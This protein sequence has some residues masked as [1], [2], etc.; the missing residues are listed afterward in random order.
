MQ[1]DILKV[2]TRGKNGW[3]ANGV[4]SR[5]HKFSSSGGTLEGYLKEAPDGTPVVDAE[6]A[7]YATFAH[8]VI[9]GPILDCALPPQTIKRFQEQE[10]LASMLPGLEGSF[11]NIGLAALAGVSSLDC[12]SLDIHLGLMRAIPGVKIGKVQDGQ[13]EWEG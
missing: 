7:D 3:Y 2:I 8:F 10:T 4:S 5:G 11:H 6:D 1:G 9:G 13:V 12:V